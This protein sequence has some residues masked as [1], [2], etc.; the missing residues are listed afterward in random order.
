MFKMDFKK[1]NPAV[2]KSMFLQMDKETFIANMELLNEKLLNIE[3]TAKNANYRYALLNLY[4]WCIDI[5]FT[6]FN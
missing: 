1:T 2:M 5:Y 6:K 4:K 3:V